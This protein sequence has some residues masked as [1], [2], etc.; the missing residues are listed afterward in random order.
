M[1]MVQINVPPE[2][3]NRL[4]RSWMMNTDVGPRNRKTLTAT[5]LA[6]AKQMKQAPSRGEVSSIHVVVNLEY[7][8]TSNHRQVHA[9]RR[10]TTGEYQ[11]A[12]S[13]PQ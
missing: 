1:T 2:N 3:R 4:F 12:T 13:K 7:A 11:P 8:T 9:P 5:G 10:Y 6:R